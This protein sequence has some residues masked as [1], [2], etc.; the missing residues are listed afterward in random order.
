VE[1]AA[2]PTTLLRLDLRGCGALRKIGGLSGLANLEKLD[3]RGCWA[4][5]GEKLPG[6][7]T[8]HSLQTRLE[9]YYPIYYSNEVEEEEQMMEDLEKGVIKFYGRVC[10]PRTKKSR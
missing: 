5:R 3:I 10:F 2:L 8:L 9:I 6:L 4:L 1:V 7:E